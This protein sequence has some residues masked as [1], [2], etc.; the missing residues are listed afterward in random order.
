[1]RYSFSAL[2]AGS[3]TIGASLFN[4]PNHPNLNSLGHCEVSSPVRS[5]N[6][7]RKNLSVASAAFKA[8]PAVAR[9]KQPGLVRAIL[10]EHQSGAVVFPC[11]KSYQH[12]WFFLAEAARHLPLGFGR[13]GGLIGPKGRNSYCHPN[14]NNLC[15]PFVP[16]HRRSSGQRSR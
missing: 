4:A 14:R 15:A 3:L 8:K 6:P 1:M 11:F 7:A 16:R 5:S 13:K 2:K 10:N 12:S 9:R